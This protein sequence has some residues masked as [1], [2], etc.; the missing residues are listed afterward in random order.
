M[1]KVVA[2]A[3]MIFI[4]AGMLEYGIEDKSLTAQDISSL[5]Q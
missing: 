3:A 1:I 2:S 4:V 5:T